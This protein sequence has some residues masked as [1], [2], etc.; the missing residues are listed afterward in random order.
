MRKPDFLIPARIRRASLCFVVISMVLLLAALANGQTTGAT[1]GATPM[2]LQ[3]GAPA[4]SYTLS[5]FDT[6]NPYNGNLNFR[7][8]LVS[9]AGRGDAR[10]TM[11]LPIEQ[12]WTVRHFENDY[13]ESNYPE[14]NVWYG[15]KPGY[16]PGVL[17]GRPVND[18]ACAP[19]Y[20]GTTKTLT[21]LTFIAPD[22]TEYELR[23]QNTGGQPQQSTCPASQSGSVQGFSR[24]TVFITA[25]GTATTFVSDAPIYDHSGGSVGA[26]WLPEILY[27]SGYLMFRNG[28]RYR[29]DSG[30]VSWIRDRNGNQ[31]I[32]AYGQYG[33]TSIT[34]SLNRQ[35][36]LTYADFQATFSDVITYKGFGG[37]PRAIQV[38][39]DTLDHRLRTNRPG[40]S[41][42]PLSRAQLFPELNGSDGTFAPYVVSS[43]T[44]PN[45]TQTYQFFYD[46][47]AELARVILPTGGAFEYDFGNGLV[48]DNADG[49][50]SAATPPQIYR[51]ALAR[52][53]YSDAGNT[54]ESE[55]TYSRPESTGGT[56]PYVQV[57]HF[58]ADGASRVAGER[59]YFYGAAVSASLD[60]DAFSYPNWQ[61]GK[62]YQSDALQ[63]DGSTVLRTVANSWQQGVIVSAW[64]TLIPNNPRIAESTSTLADVGPSLVSRQSYSYDDSVP[65]N[66]KSD[67]YE[68]DY[69][70]GA[71]GS[72]V[73][74]T[75]TDYVTSTAYVDAVSG[76]HLR[77][78]PSQVT[79]YDAGGIERA[80][81]TIEYDNYASDGNHSALVDRPD[82][83][84]LNSSFTSSYWQ[85]GGATATTRYLFNTGGQV[86][87]SITA[88]AQYDV[89]GNVVKAIDARGYATTFDF[90]DRFGSAPDGEA[91]S[92]TPPSELSSPGQASYAFATLV[93]NA[94]SQ[95]VYTQ[96]DY[97]LGRPIDLEDAN[98]VT[99][100]AWYNDTLDRPTQVIR[101]AN[102][103][104]TI[105]N[106]TTFAY[107][108]MAHVITTSNDQSNNNDNALVNRVLYDGL[109]RTTEK[110]QYEG[111]SNYIVVQQQYDAM[112]R[113]YRTSNPFRPWQSENA[114]W[115]TTVFDALGRVTSVT[116]PDS[117]TVSTSYSGNA[118]T[119]TDQAGKSRKSVSDALGRLRQIYEDPSGLN[120]Q[121]IYDYDVLDDLTQVSQGSQTRTFVYDSLKRIASATNP[122]SG[123][124]SYQYDNNGNLTQ[125][126][127]ARPVTTTINYDPLNRPTSRTYGDGTPAV[128]YFYDNQGLP[129]GA[130]AFSSGSSI[131]R[132]IAIT[133]GTVSSAG[134]YTGY[135]ALGRTTLSIQQ[136]GA[137]NYQVSAAYNL[138]G[139]M[140]SETYPSGR[141]VSYGYDSADRLSNFTGNLGDGTGRTYST[142][143]A[144]S[145]WGSLSQEQYGT[146]TTV[147]RRLFYNSRGQLTLI[148]VTTV[149]DGTTWNR[150]KIGNRYS[151]Q[152]NPFDPNCSGSDNNGNLGVQDIFIPQDD[153]AANY[154]SWFDAYNYDSLNRLITV[155]EGAHVQPPDC[156]GSGCSSWGQTYQYDRYGNRT[157]DPAWT[158]GFPKPQFA[159]DP[160]TNRLGVPNGQS[161]T[162]TYDNAGNLIYDSY[163]GEGTRTY[164]AENRMT[165]AWANSQWQTYTYDGG[166]HRVRRN[167]N[168]TETWQVYGIA[169]ELLA[170]YAANNDPS[171]P[172]KEYGYRNG[173]LLVT[174]EPSAN[175]HWLITDQLGTPRMIFDN[176]GSLSGM[177]RHDFLP[178]GEESYA[179][180]NGRTTALGYTGDST[181]QSSPVMR[182]TAKPN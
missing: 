132:L 177:S 118:V 38:N 22:G 149:N 121:T 57:D 174:A 173:Q 167:V 176:S 36:T 98:G 123:T 11:S 95:R 26:R 124:I 50:V 75:H 109:G 2:A 125:R 58:K 83:S 112:S 135:D 72:L 164:D 147:N 169:G 47:Y 108:D 34:D 45:G 68:Y 51:R 102:Q 42:V 168:G 24:G 39:Y 74:R 155:V 170:E 137:I 142:G 119:A 77:S 96:F 131:G 157:I 1:D 90:S 129:S 76:A 166:G 144:Y 107:D 12:H 88:Y 53:V 60:Q 16:G 32:F 140:T 35:I 133:Y 158:W 92:N 61:D 87:G 127:D 20:Y 4:G 163:T 41:P 21:R 69:G 79:V 56:T 25:D 136:T 64:N 66:N 10:Y 71:A 117:A 100:S 120:Y 152:C 148:G 106:Q 160:N 33:V 104:S 13:Q 181:R 105:K 113:V 143:I 89:A 85:R 55:M 9:A 145:D 44:L 8:P 178:F 156:P 93:T 31:L 180:T 19:Y 14:M 122:E 94:M 49:V 28:V 153:Q 29:I 97:Y 126:T 70:P 65:Y 82:I 23:D 27:P 172:Q 154:T 84:G 103:G 48:G 159:V 54:L 59:H 3:P 179:G 115:T 5:A 171:N 101:G 134:R 175:I 138:A 81:T 73:R 139:N 114:L 165:T 128:S 91:E 7:L 130:P 15:L 67:V 151:S 40:D 182:Q 30:Y 52:R 116:T 86:S 99:F 62:E 18:G 111:T 162:M 78:L 6:I 150:G 110:R 17:L 37:A 63:T 161:G 141:S 80:R 146:S 46:V 43:V